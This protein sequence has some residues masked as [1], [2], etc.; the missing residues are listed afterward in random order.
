MANAG[1]FA[2][3]CPDDR[4]ADPLLERAGEL[5]AAGHRL[6]AAAGTL[7]PSLATLLRAMLSY[8][9]HRIEGQH[10][11]P[12]DIER[13]L[14]KQFDADERQASRQRLALAHMDAEADVEGVRRAEA[15]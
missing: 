4:A 6:S 3:L 14:A 11:R 7:A 2:P 9:T 1:A 15:I 5:I 12:A 8:Y 10:T 13:G